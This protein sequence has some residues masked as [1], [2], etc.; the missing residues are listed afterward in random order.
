MLRDPLVFLDDI[1]EA[2]DAVTSYSGS[3]TFEEFRADRKTVDAVV[4][5]LEVIGE[6]VKMLRPEI[7][8]E[9]PE[10]EWQRIAGLRDILIHHYFGL[11]LNLIWDVIQTKV[12]VLRARVAEYRE[13][14]GK[15]VS[16]G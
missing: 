6:A 11:D 7:R 14:A 10:I 1:V 4:R 9:M 16:G 5:N 8:D 12:P 13:R 2:C 3:L 15:N